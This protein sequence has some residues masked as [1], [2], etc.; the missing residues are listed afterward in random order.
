MREEEWMSE[1]TNNGGNTTPRCTA[2]GLGTMPEHAAGVA[3]GGTGLPVAFFYKVAPGIPTWT[4]SFGVCP[5][6]PVGF[7]FHSYGAAS[8]LQAVYAWQWPDRA[9]A[10]GTPSLGQRVSL[11]CWKCTDRMTSGHFPITG[12][13]ALASKK[14]RSHQVHVCMFCVV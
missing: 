3:R 13:E 5:M 11:L 2:V 10:Q 8:R 4:K 12:T 14:E 7:S 6:G 9:C 1:R